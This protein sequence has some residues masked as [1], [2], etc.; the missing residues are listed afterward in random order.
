M[1]VDESNFPTLSPSIWRSKGCRSHFFV[2]EGLIV[3]C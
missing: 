1:T 3:W 2:R